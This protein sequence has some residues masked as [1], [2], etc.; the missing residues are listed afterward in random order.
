MDSVHTVKPYRWGDTWVFDDPAKGLRAAPILVA[1]RDTIAKVL[2]QVVSRSAPRLLMTF[3]DTE[4][5]WAGHRLT[6]YWTSEN[7][8]GQWYNA[9]G[10]TVQCPGLLRYFDAVPRTIFCSITPL[11]TPFSIFHSEQSYRPRPFSTGRRH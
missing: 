8:Q 10:L 2:D 9:G 11:R 5:P 1:G 4:F 3:S 6:L 7:N